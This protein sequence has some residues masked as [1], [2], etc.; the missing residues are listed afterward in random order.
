M[1]SD[2]CNELTAV[3]QKDCYLC[4]RL[5][6]KK[7]TVARGEQLRLVLGNTL[8]QMMSRANTGLTTVR[9]QHRARKVAVH[10]LDAFFHLVRLV[11]TSS[12]TRSNLCQSDKTV[13]LYNLKNSL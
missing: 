7:G 9:V 12:T 2:W 1:A 6:P 10:G 5:L 4:E 8:H 13:I 11:R 3:T